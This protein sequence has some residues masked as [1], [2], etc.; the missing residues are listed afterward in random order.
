MP[1]EFA[2]AMITAQ[3]VEPPDV[4]RC[5][6]VSVGS[7]RAVAAKADHGEQATS[8]R[9]KAAPQRSRRRDPRDH[10]DEAGDGDHGDGEGVA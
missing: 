9:S 4:S 5:V 7:S 10:R 8:R 6:Q 2:A 3:R 1:T